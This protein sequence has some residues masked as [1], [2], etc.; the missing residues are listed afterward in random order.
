M[1]LGDQLEEDEETEDVRA[2]YVSISIR[3]FA[4]GTCSCLYVER[5]LGSLLPDA[6]LPSKG[7]RK[8]G[9]LLE[10]SI[11]M[12]FCIVLAGMPLDCRLRMLLSN[13]LKNLISGHRSEFSRSI[14]QVS[15]GSSFRNIAYMKQQ[16]KDLACSFDWK[17]VGQ[18]MNEYH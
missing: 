16:I 3:S 4:H 18:S 2:S 12:R 6:R 10:N 1:C 5:C 9:T 8:N 13:D 11:P 17:R 7:S 15:F 14:E